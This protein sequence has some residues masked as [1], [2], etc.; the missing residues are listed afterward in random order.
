MLALPPS[1]MEMIAGRP[2]E[3]RSFTTQLRPETLCGVF[4]NAIRLEIPRRAYMS[5][6]APDL[7]VYSAIRMNDKTGTYPASLRT[8]IATRPARFAT[9][10]LVPAAIPL[11]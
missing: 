9:P 11:V 7:V 5:E 1:D 3:A 6:T 4:S 2:V 8:L 10:Y